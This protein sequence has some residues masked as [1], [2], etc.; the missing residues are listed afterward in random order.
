MGLAT[1]IDDFFAKW[2][3]FEWM[4]S[5]RQREKNTAVVLST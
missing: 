1:A 3:L 4:L 2:K 5:H